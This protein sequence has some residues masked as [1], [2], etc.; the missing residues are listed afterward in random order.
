V[1]LVRH[2][3]RVKKKKS[4]AKKKGNS[5]GAAS[6]YMPNKERH[7]PKTDAE[8]FFYKEKGHWKRNCPKYLAEN[9]KTGASSSGI[10][11]IHI[12]DVYLTS[13]KSNSWVFDTRSIANIC[14]TMQEVRVTRTLDKDEVTMHVGNRARV[15]VIAVSKLPLHLLLGFILELS[16][17]YFVLALC[18]NTISGYHILQDGYSFKSENNGCSIYMNNIFYGHVPIVDGLFIMNLESETNVFN[19]DATHRKTNDLNSTYLWHCRLGHIRLK[20]IKKLHQD[21]LF[22]VTQHTI[23]CCGMQVVDI[24][25]MNYHFTNYIPQSGTIES[26]MYYKP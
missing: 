14:N 18:K 24:T 10:S 19:T 17:Y 22:V 23:A 8:C 3:T 16:N 9:N 13:P 4:E 1:L 12:I 25:L 7:R 20:R 2:G 21:G 6:S 26:I 11:D 5:K 15:A